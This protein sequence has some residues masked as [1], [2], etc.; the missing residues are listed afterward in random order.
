M[1]V[2]APGGRLEV[3]RL[4]PFFHHDGVDQ[5][6]ARYDPVGG[7][8]VQILQMSRWLASHG[9][10]QLVVTVG[11]PGLPTEAEVHPGLR[12]RIARLR[13]PEVRSE[14]AGLVGLV[15]GWFVAS[16]RECH[17]LRRQGY[18]PDLVHV[19]ADGQPY[20]LWMV[21]LAKRLFRSPVALTVHCS[22]LAGYQPV[23]RLD[24]M[25]HRGV[26]RS[27]KKALGR[28]DA[29]FTLTHATADLVRPYVGDRADRC[30]VIPDT[31]DAASLGGGVPQSQIR[32]FRRKHGLGAHDEL[33]A[34][35]G[36]IAPEKGWPALLEVARALR[37]RP[38]RILIVG[39]GP[40]RERLEGEVRKAG[41][42]DTF[43]ITGF[44]PHHQVLAALCTVRAVVMPS[45]HEELGGV[46]LEAMAIGVPVVAYAV[47]GLVTT[48]GKAC[49]EMLV[50]PGDTDLLAR[51][52]QDVLE[53]PERYRNTTAA[54]Q[55]WV[56]DTYDV[57]RV[58][59]RL[60]GT[61]RMLTT[62]ND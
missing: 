53:R 39:D 37:D 49:P 2:T 26:V 58:L 48:I 35:V 36:R 8:Q 9:V 18:H 30:R 42:A 19:H 17:R 1:A 43:L 24:A 38:C 15:P 54:A 11:F 4:T 60:L 52:L 57:D 59:D 14:S 33:V 23:S 29:V 27:E 10:D 34:F 28:A 62:T 3:L 25:L 61:Y 21:S 13:L 12:V 44:I 47:G 6:P 31:I 7:M 55:K 5:W 20:A 46:A 56:R 45:R 51:K 22:R 50:P 16:L 41:L 40:Q 32:S